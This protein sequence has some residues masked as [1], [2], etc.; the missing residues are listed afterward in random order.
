MVERTPPEDGHENPAAVRAMYRAM[1]HAVT[2]SE[3]LFDRMAA[4][5]NVYHVGTRFTITPTQ[6][7][8]YLFVDNSDVD[9]PFQLQA[10]EI[11]V[12]GGDALIYVRDEPSLDSSTF[13]QTE[14]TNV[15]S[16]V[17]PG[18]D[19][20]VYFGYDDDVTISDKG[21]VYDEDFI[22]AAAGD[23]GEASTGA[24]SNGKVRYI[25]GD[26]STAMLEIQNDSS[27]EIE[28]SVSSFFHY[29]PD[30]PSIVTIANKEP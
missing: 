20:D 3:T 4:L 6:G 21:R 2:P 25:I 16:D 9:D 5:G 27:N 23:P 8:A 29:V 10:D 1:E 12:D 7:S 26:D 13:T 15:R 19:A 18:P 24:G 11:K 14:F 28:V 22:K 30:V 17:I